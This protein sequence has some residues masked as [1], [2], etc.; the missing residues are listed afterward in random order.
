MA[1]DFNEFMQETLDFSSMLYKQLR[2]DDIQS[3]FQ[4]ACREFSLQV[5][6]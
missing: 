5:D 2:E 4:D 6:D 3:I 1:N